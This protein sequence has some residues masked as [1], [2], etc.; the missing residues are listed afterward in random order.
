MTYTK[1]KIT[2]RNVY[3]RA[4]ETAHQLRALIASSENPGLCPSI[5]TAAYNCL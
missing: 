2:Y 5:H 3:I 1:R 4:A